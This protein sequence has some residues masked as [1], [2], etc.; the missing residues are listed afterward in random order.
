MMMALPSMQNECPSCRQPADEWVADLC[1]GKIE[2][3]CARCYVQFH[4]EVSA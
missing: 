1:R 2:F 4:P 3:I